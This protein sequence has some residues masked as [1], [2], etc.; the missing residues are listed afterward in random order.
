MRFSLILAALMLFF[1]GCA[2]GQ[3]EIWDEEKLTAAFQESA[4]KEG[5]IFVEDLDNNGSPELYAIVENADGTGSKLHGFDGTGKSLGSISMG[6]A[7]DEIWR[8]NHTFNEKKG[9]LYLESRGYACAGDGEAPYTQHYI[10]LKGEQLHSKDVLVNNLLGKTS[11]VID[12]KTITD[13]QEHRKALDD[14]FLKDGENEQLD[15]EA[16]TEESLRDVLNGIEIEG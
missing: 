2:A 3:K 16:F 6:L 1:C 4:V 10:T 13:H 8:V 11:Y 7:A 9:Y 14:Y 12:G 15:Y 5:I